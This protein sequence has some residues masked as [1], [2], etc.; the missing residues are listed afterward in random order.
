M[1]WWLCSPEVRGEHKMSEQNK[2]MRLWLVVSVSAIILAAV[3][4]WAVAKKQH[5]REEVHHGHFPAS[6]ELP[7]ENAIDASS[8]RMS[9]SD[10]IKTATTWQPAYTSWYGKPAPDF[11]LTDIAGKQHKL[12]DCRGKDVML[13]FW[14]TWCR[15]CLMEIP[16]LIALQNIIERDNLPIAILA[17]SNEPP[18]SVKRFAADKKINY[19]LL[20]NKAD[21]SL[22]FNLVNAIPCSFFIDTEGKIKL[23]TTGVLTLGAMKAILQAPLEQGN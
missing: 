9:L 1:V 16:H 20:L 17:I 15:P 4:I 23:A 2:Q 8:S 22:P 10:I 6:L 21:M 13:V 18:A 14:A 12:S 11:T 5:R 3:V 19:P 7:D